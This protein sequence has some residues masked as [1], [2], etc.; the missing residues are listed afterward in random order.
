MSV[1]ALIPKKQYTKTFMSQTG[2]SQPF[3]NPTANKGEAGGLT[4]T[5]NNHFT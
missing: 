1:F 5:C 2:I 3:P 4:S